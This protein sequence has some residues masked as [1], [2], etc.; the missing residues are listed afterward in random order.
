[1]TMS[2][3]AVRGDLE[4][5]HGTA[6]WCALADI[7]LFVAPDVC[8]GCTHWHTNDGDGLN[9]IESRK[10]AGVLE[11]RLSDGTIDQ[12]IGK[13]IAFAK[14]LPDEPCSNCSGTGVRTDAVAVR[15]GFD[16]RTID[17]PSHPRFGQVG[18]CNGCRGH[19]V[20]RALSAHYPLE[21][22]KIVAELVSFLKASDGFRIW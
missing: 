15:L 21:D 8:S 22:S 10:L 20:R 3:R 9:A 19:G 14:S 5:H 13:K 1:M 16:R 4:F 2:V 18:Y 17:D 11:Q 12:W 6:T 7:C